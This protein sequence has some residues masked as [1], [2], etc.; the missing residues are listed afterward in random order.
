MGIAT[1]G[2][3]LV[4]DVIS[5]VKQSKNLHKGTKAKSAEEL[6]QQARELEEKLEALIQMYEGLQA[7]SRR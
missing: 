7:G 3:S 4:G 5:L 6:R 2:V 1:A